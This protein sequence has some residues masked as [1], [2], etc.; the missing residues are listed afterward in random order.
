MIFFM[1]IILEN[2]EDEVYEFEIKF[3][4][5]VIRASIKIRVSIFEKIIMR[6]FNVKF[7]RFFFNF[8]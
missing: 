2:V 7:A 6:K 5:Y 4:I 3:R 1:N 8:N